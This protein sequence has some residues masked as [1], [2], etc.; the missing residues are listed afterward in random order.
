MV[1]PSRG[2]KN[3]PHFFCENCGA[4]VP[5]SA[6]SCPQCGRYFASV[7]CPSCGFTGEA[8][9]F[10]NGCKVCGY[11]SKMESDFSFKSPNIPLE[12]KKPAAA[13]PAWVYI[14]TAAIFTIIMTALLFT[15]FK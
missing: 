6:D 5:R 13:L 4:E 3:T 10:K 2:G 15:L 11:S 12:D 14:L 8:S 7:R 9:L 1:N